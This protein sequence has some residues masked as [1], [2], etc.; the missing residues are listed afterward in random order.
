M[1]EKVDQNKLA[2]VD[3]TNKNLQQVQTEV[4]NVLKQK[5]DI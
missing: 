5:L 1:F 3:I 2:I 4:K